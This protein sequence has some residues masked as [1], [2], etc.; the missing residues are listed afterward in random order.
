VKVFHFIADEMEKSM[1]KSRLGKKAP[2]LATVKNRAR[3]I[4]QLKDRCMMT[5]SPLFNMLETGLD[6]EHNDGRPDLL[7]TA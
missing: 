7:L 5:A 2:R 6:D 4:E 1:K 3:R